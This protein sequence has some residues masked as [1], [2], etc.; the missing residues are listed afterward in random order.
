M[1]TAYGGRAAAYQSK[2]E[3]EKAL[4]DH[5]M[6]VLFCALEVEILS[7]LEAPQRDKFLAEAAAAYRARGQCLESLGRLLA[8]EADQKRADG[9]EADATKVAAKAKAAAVGEVRLVN[10]WTR[11]VTI[12]VDGVGYRLEA[13]EQKAIPVRSASV[14]FEMRAGDSRD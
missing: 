6:V 7:T 3:F 4:A 12:E 2:G 13:G 5:N 11:A 9:L 8:A 1:R 14:P 10:A